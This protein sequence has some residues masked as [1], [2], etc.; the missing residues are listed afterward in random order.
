MLHL[1][2]TKDWATPQDLV[3]L[4]SFLRQGALSRYGTRKFYNSLVRQSLAII[5]D[6]VLADSFSHAA[7][8]SN[9]FSSMRVCWFPSSKCL[10]QYLSLQVSGLFLSLLKCHHPQGSPNFALATPL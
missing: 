8:Y 3:L 10:L 2:K 9:S 6:Q 1:G 5:Q 7:S 4:S